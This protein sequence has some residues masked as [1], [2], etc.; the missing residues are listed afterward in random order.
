MKICI[1]AG[2]N[3]SG[4]DTG[5][6]GWGLREQDISFQIAHKL[7]AKLAALGAQVKETRP[8]QTTKLG[9]SL[10]SSLQTRCDIANNF[11]ADYFISIHCNA[12]TSITATGTET[13]IY[14][15]GGEAEKM[16]NAVQI[17]LV[18]VIGTV[19]RG[20]KT[21]NVK[22]LR[23]TNM[24]AILIEVGFITNANDVD[25]LENKQDLIVD[26]IVK[27]LADYTGLKIENSE[28][29]NMKILFVGTGRNIKAFKEDG[30][31]VGVNTLI[32]CNDR[33]V[34]TSISGFLKDIGVEVEWREE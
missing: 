18:E 31:E 11:G 23:S 6:S 27:G 20:V 2:H 14:A 29:D 3:N 12:A 13:L 22:V 32:E 17:N 33:T 10:D 15:K 24:P 25:I 9:T 16:A 21:Q 30:K 26:G 1:D 8:T 28:D 7:A 4:Y 19:S 34:C 5:A